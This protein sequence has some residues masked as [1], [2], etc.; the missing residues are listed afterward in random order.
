MEV[1][2]QEGA[3]A[4]DQGTVSRSP[5]V[6]STPRGGTLADVLDAILDKGIV[7]DAWARVSLV[8]I[9]V[10]TVEARVVVASVDTYLRYADAIRAAELAA[11]P[12]SAEAAPSRQIEVSEKPS[13][14]TPPPEEAPALS[15]DDVAGYLAEHTE[16]LRLDDLEEHFHAARDVI[17]PVIEQLLS[18]QRARKN[19][20][21]VVF[22]KLGQGGK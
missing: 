12:P 5:A 18:A 16:G 4:P 11:R 19:D 6:R 1:R 14:V 9:E 22:P 21:N 2:N 15:A 10:L 8:G 13:I 20:A 17:E 3:L 7:I